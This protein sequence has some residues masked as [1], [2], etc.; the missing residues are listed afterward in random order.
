LPLLHDALDLFLHLDRHLNSYASVHQVGVYVLLGTIVFCETGL[1]VWPFLPGDSLLFA[2]GALAAASGSPISLPGVII[3]L[4]LAAN[5]GDV[6]NYSIGRRIGPKI[7]SRESSWMLNKRHL[8]EA[9]RF[10]EKHGRKTIILARFVPIIRTFAPLVAGIG[11][12]PFARFIGFS[13]SGGVLWVVTLSLAGYYF[14]Q[15]EIVRTH[16]Q[17]V[18]MAIVAISLIPVAVHALRGRMRK[19]P[20]KLESLPVA[21]EKAQ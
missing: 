12:M 5:C 11:Q 21:D 6:L 9:H 7:F 10:Y 16:F 4:C 8:E 13:I 18:V 17:F 3:L 14:N 15:I 2:V 20:R 1:V 19:N